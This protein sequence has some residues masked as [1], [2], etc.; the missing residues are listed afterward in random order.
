VIAPTQINPP[1][2][3]ISRPCITVPKA[4]TT[5]VMD[6]TSW[7]YVSNATLPQR[8][9]GWIDSGAG[10][11]SQLTNE[12]GIANIP[13]D[14]HKF[15][16]KFPDIADPRLV[17]AANSAVDRRAL[18][19][20]IK[21]CKSYVRAHLHLTPQAKANK[22]LVYFIARRHPVTIEDRGDIVCISWLANTT[23]GVR[24]EIGLSAGE[25]EAKLGHFLG[26]RPSE[27]RYLGR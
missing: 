16:R 20:A 24:V 13:I 9:R 7:L 17:L 25:V 18:F 14:L 4:T 6:K 11:K 2:I 27:T 19:M 12:L 21:K 8:R 5:K 22:S 1:N 10:W 3:P 15:E 26:A 23:I